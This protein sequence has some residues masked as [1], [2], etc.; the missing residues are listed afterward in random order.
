MSISYK[1]GWVIILS[2]IAVLISIAFILPLQSNV[3]ET[4]RF[5]SQSDALFRQLL[6][7]TTWHRWWPGKTEVANQKLLFVH[8]GFT[9][10]VDRI[11]PNTFELK[12]TADSFKTN[13]TLRLIP[14]SGNNVTMALTT[15]IPVPHN[16]IDRIK[17]L[18]ASSRLKSVYKEILI[19]LSRYFTS[20]KN[21]YDIDIKESN[22]SFEYVTAVSQTF[23]HDPSISEIYFLIDKVR[24]FMKNNGGIEKGFPML[25]SGEVS[26]GQFFVQV[27]IPTNKQLPSSNEIKSKWMLKGGHILTA[28]VTGN[29]QI[30]SNAMKQMEYYIQD[31]HRNTVAIA[32][33]YLITNRLEQ[34]D[35]NR[36]VT[37]IYFPVI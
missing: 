20:I 8:N 29:R 35:S 19:R 36:W 24:V 7:D 32:Y 14:Q 31:N 4:I 21:L 6:N 16:P 26:K 3:N 11:L 10:T 18:V 1:K 25:H 2:I 15:N 30:I 12:I 5:S 13:S 9:F 33:E 34:P 37:G 27:A 22:V 17:T 28:Q 23:S